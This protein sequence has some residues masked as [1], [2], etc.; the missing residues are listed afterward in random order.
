[1]G[2]ISEFA[3]FISEAGTKQTE[4]KRTWVAKRLSHSSAERL[5]NVPLVW[6]RRVGQFQFIVNESYGKLF[7][8]KIPWKWQN[9]L[10]LF[11]LESNTN[12]TYRHDWSPQFI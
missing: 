1:M 12:E 2:W 6:F 4:H 3:I 7:V 5:G 8:M 11:S 10:M 9:A